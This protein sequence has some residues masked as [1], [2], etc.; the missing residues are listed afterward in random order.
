ML[1]KVMWVV[2][3]LSTD[4]LETLGGHCLPMQ[5]M[6]NIQKGFMPVYCLCLM[7]YFNNFSRGAWLYFT[8]HGSYGVLWL[9]AYC[10]FPNKGFSHNMTIGACIN[11]Y[12]TVLG[13]YCL[14][15]YLVNS[16]QIPEA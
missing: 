16:R 12:A 8:L 13:P 5:A 9:M 7:V 4:F 10:I 3:Y 2:D 11:M 1:E 6:I 15:A 14:A